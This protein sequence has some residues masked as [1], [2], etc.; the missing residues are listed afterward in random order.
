MFKDLD[1]EEAVHK[2]LHAI[3]KEYGGLK[4]VKCGL[5][6]KYVK[7]YLNHVKTCTGISVSNLINYFLQN[8]RSKDISLTQFLT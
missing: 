1:D 2:Y 4:C 3:T 8:I 7:S 6:R 5:N